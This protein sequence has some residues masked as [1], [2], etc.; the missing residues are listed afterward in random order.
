LLSFELRRHAV[1]V[2]TDF[3]EDL[4]P[5][6]GDRS[7]LER[8]VANLIANGVEAMSS[9]QDRQ[10]KLRISTQPNNRGAVLVAVEDSGTA[11]DPADLDRIFDPCFTTKREGTGL[12]LSVCRSIVEAHGGHLWATPN[13]PHGSTFRFVIPHP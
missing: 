13:I 7:Q 11:L 1:A 2:E 4:R 5:I 10:R 8:V 12:G 9:V 3:A 6:R